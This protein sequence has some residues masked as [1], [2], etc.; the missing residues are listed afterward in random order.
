MNIDVTIRNESLMQTY[1]KKIIRLAAPIQ[2]GLVEQRGA[3]SGLVER[4]APGQR[5]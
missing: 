2:L 5:L 3:W 4:S 1:L